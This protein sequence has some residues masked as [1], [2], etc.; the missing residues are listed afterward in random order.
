MSIASIS[1]LAGSMPD[2]W[3]VAH[4]WNA[5][6]CVLIIATPIGNAFDL[7]DARL[8][9]EWNEAVHPTDYITAIT[10]MIGTPEECR[11]EAERIVNG[12]DHKPR[13]NVFGKTTGGRIECSNGKIYETQ[14]EACRDLNLNHSHVSRML[15]GEL[16]TVRG[17]V[18]RYIGA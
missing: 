17:Y 6:V 1:A 8:N 15:K 16:K 4:Y 5:G 18:F 3:C 10:T 14:A 2:A 7:S 11:T 12:M 13:C 9:S